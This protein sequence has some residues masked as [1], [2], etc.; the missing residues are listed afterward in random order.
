MLDDL[1][2]KS[3]EKDIVKFKYG[4]RG[5]WCKLRPSTYKPFY[6]EISRLDKKNNK[7][8]SRWKNNNDQK[9]QNDLATAIV[10]HLLIDWYYV[11]PRETFTL[12]FPDIEVTSNKDLDS[13]LCEVPFSKKNAY[14][15]LKN[16]QMLEF[17]NTLL[18][19]STEKENFKK[20][21]FEDDLKN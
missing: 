19:D 20:S 5:N 14:D 13:D 17:L 15:I 16:K 6:T 7:H 12:L 8:N 4:N 21:N 18:S 9:S 3:K 10:N 1:L 11:A 2:V